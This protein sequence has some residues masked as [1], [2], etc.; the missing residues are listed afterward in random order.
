MLEAI[1]L[2]LFSSVLGRF[3]EGLGAIGNGED[4]GA[5]D[6]IGLAF[7]ITALAAFVGSIIIA[8]PYLA[9]IFLD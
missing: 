9:N 1:Y 4:F 3:G 8:Y 5:M 7:L 2:L 6:F